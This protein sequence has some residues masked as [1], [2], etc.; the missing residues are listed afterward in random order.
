MAKKAG[1]QAAHRAIKGQPRLAV[2][3][4]CRVVGMTAQNYYARRRQR[5]RRQVDGD[6]VCQ[7]V[8][9]ERHLQPR[10][11]TRK[12]RVLLAAPLHERV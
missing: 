6:L 2:M 7:L 8:R 5:Q 3:V 4:V 12:L 9:A 11:G 10:L 1:W